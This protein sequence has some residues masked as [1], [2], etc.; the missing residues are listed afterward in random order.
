MPL[1]VSTQ[2]DGMMHQAIDPAGLFTCLYQCDAS[3]G[4]RRLLADYLSER[5]AHSSY[6]EGPQ[7]F[8]MEVIQLEE[9]LDALASYLMAACGQGEWV[10]VRSD[11]WCH[12]TFPAHS[13][14]IVIVIETKRHRAFEFQG[15]FIDAY[16][17]FGG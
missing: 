9:K 10:A 5:L 4:G 16:A 7:R 1:F 6:V 11:A 2:H 15:I 12:A 3:D 13:S 17:K 8:D 14:F